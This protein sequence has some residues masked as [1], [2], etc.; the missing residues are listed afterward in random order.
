MT[1]VYI[2]QE[3]ADDFSVVN[4]ETE[5]LV[6]GIDSGDFDVSIF[7]P[8]GDN[9]ADGTGAVTWDLDEKFTGSGYYK[10]SFTPNIEGDWLVSVTH[11]TYFPWGKSSN[12]A[13]VQQ[14]YYSTESP[15]ST[16]MSSEILDVLD[17]L[18]V[19]VLALQ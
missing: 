11:D 10:F 13:A 7:D 9:R 17:D 1:Y 15:D 5:A 19:F 4:R 2:D 16:S 18:L 14:G 3:C 8:N 12:F 6:G